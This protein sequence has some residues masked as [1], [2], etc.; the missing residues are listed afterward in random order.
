MVKAREVFVMYLTAYEDY[1]KLFQRIDQIEYI[2]FEI[3]RNYIQ[4]KVL[5]SVNKT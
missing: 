3:P 5:Q 4:L 1:L 2:T